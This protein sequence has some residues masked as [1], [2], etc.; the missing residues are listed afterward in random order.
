MRG[1]METVHYIEKN[2]IR[3]KANN[4]HNPDAHLA[5]VAVEAI[6]RNY[7]ILIKILLRGDKISMAQKQD[8]ERWL[9][10]D[11]GNNG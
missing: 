5:E 9:D 2:R 4:T 7:K 10:E 1:I 11:E 8:L 6:E 3:F